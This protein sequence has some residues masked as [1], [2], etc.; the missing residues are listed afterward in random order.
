MTGRGK[1]GKG[2][3]KG[4]A[5]RHRKVLR[6]N[7]QGITKPAIRRLARRG[8]VKRISG[9]IYEETRGVLKV[10]L[11]NVIRD[12]VNYTEHAKRKT[13]TAMD[14]QLARRILECPVTME[15]S[16]GSA[17]PGPS[18]GNAVPHVGN[19]VPMTEGVGNAVPVGSAV[20]YGNAVPVGNAVQTAGRTVGNAVSVGTTALFAGRNLAAVGNAVPPQLATALPLG[21]AVPLVCVSANGNTTDDTTDGTA[22]EKQR[23]RKKKRGSQESDSPYESLKLEAKVRQLEV[24]LSNIMEDNKALSTELAVVKARQEETARQLNAE[25]Q[26]VNSCKRIIAAYEKKFSIKSDEILENSPIILED[27]SM[28]VELPTQPVRQ[29]VTTLPVAQLQVEA[30]RAPLQAVKK[31]ILPGKKDVEVAE[32]PTKAAR[33]KVKKVQIVNGTK[34]EPIATTSAATKTAAKTNKDATPGKA[35]TDPATGKVTMQPNYVFKCINCNRVGHAANA[36]DCPTRLKLLAKIAQDQ[37]AKAAKSAP[38]GFPVN[39]GKIQPSVSYASITSAKTTAPNMTLGQPPKAKTPMGQQPIS[40]LP[41]DQQPKANIAM[42]QKPKSNISL[43]QQ[44]S[45]GQ[46]VSG[47]TLF[48]EI[49]NEIFGKDFLT[50]V[51]QVRQFSEELKSQDKASQAKAMASLV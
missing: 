41:L 35:V 16:D 10:F 32:K 33:R 18:V 22:V 29:P 8:G 51:M 19:A 36:R 13:V 46:A 6:D 47:F 45:L 15:V 43:G 11:E 34:D 42:G 39:S 25:F 27:A 37:A 1:G 38:K 26:R 7:I 40:N 44:Q 21:K 48:D 3:G 5:K 31:P 4:G 49:C 23:K 14:I 50:S 30:S 17:A 2:L 28:E 20:P 12:A 24:L 9:L